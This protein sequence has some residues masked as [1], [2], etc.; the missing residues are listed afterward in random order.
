ML[1][2][3]KNGDE[4]LALSWFLKLKEGDIV[5]V[6]EPYHQY[7]SILVVKRITKIKRDKLYV[8]GDNK[9]ESS[10]SRKY[11]WI[12]RKQIIAKVIYRI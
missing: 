1:P 7:T 3:Y 12:N 8:L 10:D 5:V 11:G 2:T 9:L 6:R 4:L